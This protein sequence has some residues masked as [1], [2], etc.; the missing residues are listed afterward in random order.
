MRRRTVLWLSVAAVPVAGLAVLV[1]NKVDN[2]R[3]A[4]ARSH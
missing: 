1:M 4:A 2:V 3:E